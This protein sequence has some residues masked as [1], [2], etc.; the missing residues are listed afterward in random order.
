MLIKINKWER[1]TNN[2]NDSINFDAMFDVNA[3]IEE[4][5][6]DPDI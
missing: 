3:K 2:T 1:N 5:D 4:I 6:D